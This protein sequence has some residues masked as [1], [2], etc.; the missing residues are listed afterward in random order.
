LRGFK[1]V[2]EM[3]FGDYIWPAFMQIKNEIA[4]MRY[5]S[6]GNFSAPVVIRVAV[7]GYIHGGLYHSQNIES[8]FAHIPGLLIAYPSTAADAKGLLKTACRLQDPVIFCEHKGLYRHP[9]STTIEPDK[10]FL[11]PFGKGKIVQQ[12]NNLTI[13]TWGMS[14]KDSVNAAKRFIKEHPDFTIEIIDLRTIIPWDK[15]LVLQ[16]V[17]K[18]NRALVVH[19]DTWTNGF[20]AEIAATITQMAFNHLDAPVMRVASL[21]SHIPYHPNYEN[22]VLVTEEKIYTAINEILAY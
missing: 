4:T 21:D 16:S 14:V 9:F 12:G 10:D 18:T 20:G 8:I 5:R 11:L 2:V 19:E 22:Y 7:G 17:E 6:N 3:Q 13:V 15:E 1:P